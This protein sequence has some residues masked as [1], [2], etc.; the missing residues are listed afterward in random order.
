MLKLKEIAE[1]L[2]CRLEGDGEID[3]HRVAGIEEAGPG[4]LTFFTNPKYAAELRATRASAVILGPTGRAGAVRDAARRRSRISRSR[5]AVELFA[6]PRRPAAGR[7]SPRRRRA[8][9]RQLGAGRVDRSV[10]RRSATARAIGARTIVY[11]HVD[12]RRGT[13][14]S[15]TTASSTRACRSASACSIG[16]R[17][18][19]QDGAVIGS[20][21]FGFAHAA[22]RHPSQ[23]SADRRRRRSKT[24]WRS[25]RTRRSIVRPSAR[26]GSAPARRSTTSCRSRTA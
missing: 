17:V 12:D 21:G 6:D 1:R 22:R 4:D 14:R 7:P 19:M 10:R 20:D 5:K 25:A 26:R 18:V 3:I 8:T 2:E 9:A 13:R 23:D 11:P 24:T 16:H 15:A